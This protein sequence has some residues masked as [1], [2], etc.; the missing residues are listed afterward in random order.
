MNG[1]VTAQELDRYLTALCE[2]G[3]IYSTYDNDI[4]SV[5]DM[6]VN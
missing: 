2:D 5:T 1:R 6:W 4:Y 3:V